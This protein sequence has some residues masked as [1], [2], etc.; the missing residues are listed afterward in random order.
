MT[1][2]VL[3]AGPKAHRRGV[4]PWFIWAI[5]IVVLVVLTVVAVG[6]AIDYS[7]RVAEADRLLTAIE[8]SEAAM[9]QTQDK[10]VAALTPL[11]SGDMTAADRDKLRA[12][13]SQIAAEGQQSIS[14]AGQQVQDVSILPWH[15][16][17]KAAQAAYLAHNGA[18]VHY[19]A[20]AT[21]N[22]DEFVKAQEEVNATFAAAHQP[23]ERAIVH[24]DFMHLLDRVIAIY[25]EG[26]QDSSDPSSGGGQTA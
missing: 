1:Q 11:A 26:T 18:W 9:S 5:G 19:M 24:W 3:E 23:L 21:T 12:E 16:N 7:A 25:D 4:H 20:A 15:S 22:P 17:I 10:V 2:E 6:V 14:A 8:G 13:L